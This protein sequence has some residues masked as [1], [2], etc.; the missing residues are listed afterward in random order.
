MNTSNEDQLI[1][2]AYAV[3][4]DPSRLDQFEKFWEA[5][6]DAQ[7]QNSPEGFDIDKTPVNAHIILALDI[8]ERVRFQDKNEALAQEM[9]NSHYGF[10]FIMNSDGKIIVSNSDAKEFT[11]QASHLGDLSLDSGS[12]EKMM[13][14]ASSSKKPKSKNL[15]FFHVYIAGSDRSTC[16]F[17]APITLHMDS[18]TGD[19][20]YFLVTSVDLEIS[21]AVRDT[22][23]RSLG[24]TPAETEVAGLLSTGRT[25]KE[26][27]TIRNVK[28]TAVRA[29]I[30]SIKSKMKA[31]D[32][33]DVVRIFVSMGLRQRSVK[34]QISRMEQLR[35]G[36]GS[37]SK[38][39]LMTLRDGRTYQYFEQ[40]DPH[41]Q[42]ILQI[43]SLISG[44]EFPSDITKLLYKAGYRMISPARAGYGGSDQNPKPNISDVIGS[45]VD[46][47]IELLDHLGVSRVLIL[48]GW[49]GAF[50][51]KLALKHPRR[52]EGLVLSGAVPVWRSE[53]LNQLEPRYRNMIKTSIHAP[54]AVPYLARVTKA[55][56]DSGQS[57]LFIGGLD[58]KNR[59]DRKAL[60]HSPIYE[61]L[62]K[63]FKFLVEKGTLAFTQEL[64]SIHKD[65]T[66]DARKLTLPVTVVMGDQNTDQPKD[67]LSRYFEAVPHASFTEIKGAGTY[68][69]LTHFDDVLRAIIAIKNDR[70]ALLSINAK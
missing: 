68:Q 42:V 28:I 10:G 11:H 18:L 15:N 37:V 35:A 8:L 43:H 39:A 62:E 6:I 22:I 29:Q 30:V 33:P 59:T 31:K 16:W 66:E 48:T 53:H 14:W 2:E 32:I 13:K 12:I 27:T 58:T 34:G 25:P 36:G 60:Q 47:L 57:K 7:L 63:R 46:D 20:K 21:S 9:V 69:N 44:V 56:I 67:S 54:K 3:T 40:G 50:A 4:L 70:D 38:K 1:K 55:L 49:A 65:W 61:A 41:G 19:Q 17:M 45:G 5:Y 51:Q 24:L 23:G 52:V 26:I 64:P